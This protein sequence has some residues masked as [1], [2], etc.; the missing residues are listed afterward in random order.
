MKKEG[1][2]PTIDFD[3]DLMQDK[4]FHTYRK[5]KTAH[6]AMYFRW[7][8]LNLVNKGYVRKTDDVFE[9]VSLNFALGAF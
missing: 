8:P 2:E 9:N 5:T 7:N 3:I 6:E 4:M 1:F